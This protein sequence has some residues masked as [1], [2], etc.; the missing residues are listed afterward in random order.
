[1]KFNERITASVDLSDSYPYSQMKCGTQN[2]S[3]RQSARGST[4]SHG[5]QKG[6]LGRTS[7]SLYAETVAET[8]AVKIKMSTAAFFIAAAITPYRRRIF[9]KMLVS[10]VPTQWCLQ[11]ICRRS[12]VTL[13]LPYPTR[14]QGFMAHLSYQICSNYERTRSKEGTDSLPIS[15]RERIL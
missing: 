1:M 15:S 13:S 7:D 8:M 4:G 14:S 12:L 3:E 6:S 11:K 2:V 10:T 5:S 9:A